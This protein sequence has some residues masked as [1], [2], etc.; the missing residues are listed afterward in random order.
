M[1]KISSLR[2]ALVGCGKIA[3]RHAEH[4]DAKAELVAVCDTDQ[5]KAKALATKYQVAAHYSIE[6][7]FTNAF[8]DIAVIC[9]PNGLH[10]E[11]SVYALQK[12]VHVICEKPM[13]IRTEDCEWMIDAAQK[14]RKELFIVKQNR[15]N[16]PIVELKKAIDDGRLGRIFSVQL[17]CFWHR[18][19]DYYKEESW[20]GTKSL[21]G[22]VL[23]TQFSHFIDLMLW[24]MNDKVTEVHSVMKNYSHAGI[25]EFEDTGVVSLQFYKGAIGSIGFTTNAYRKNMEGSITIF[26][27]RGT[28]KVGGEYLNQLVYQQ[29][30]DHTI[31]DN[32]VS[33]PPNQYGSYTGSMS[34]HGLFYDNVIDVL[35]NKAAKTTDMY[36]AMKTVVLIEKIY[37][38]ANVQ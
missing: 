2:F 12:G 9:T 15:Y 24:L 4:I 38:S 27:E 5:V 13:A 17:N 23:Y 21:D 30:E 14:N 36:E 31:N 8:F 16:P 10:A 35:E 22:G 28:V 19:A 11:Q 7:L 26:G 33:S 25:T 32:N 1:P 20:R 6:D 34:N 3:H 37:K 29:I 18:D